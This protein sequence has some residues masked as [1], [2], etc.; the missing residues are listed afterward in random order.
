[1]AC[2]LETSYDDLD[3][4][5]EKETLSDDSEAEFFVPVRVE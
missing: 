4:N 1:M 5:S 2:C 3:S